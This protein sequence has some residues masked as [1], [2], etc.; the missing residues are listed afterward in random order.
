MGAYSTNI[1]NSNKKSRKMRNRKRELYWRVNHLDYYQQ[2][3]VLYNSSN[4]SSL[5]QFKPF[6]QNHCSSSS[7]SNPTPFFPF[8]LSI[9]LLCIGSKMVKNDDKWLHWI[10]ICHPHFHLAFDLCFHFKQLSEKLPTC[11]ISLFMDLEAK[12]LEI[13][14]GWKENVKIQ[15]M[16][17]FSI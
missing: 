8:F 10:L 9:F 12:P 5:E 17:K 6:W 14:I 13:L 2:A 15:V 3:C 1:Y 7:K 16:S 4:F 11:V